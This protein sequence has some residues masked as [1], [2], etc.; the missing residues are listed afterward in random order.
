M[1]YRLNERFRLRGWEKL[2][3][4]LTEPK[5]GRA[6]FISAKEMDALRL[7]NGRIDL[8]LAFIPEDIRKMLPELEK[9]G[10]I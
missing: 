6:F 7:C 5:T 9:G 4:A 10:I 8:S 1:Y 2:P 3:Y